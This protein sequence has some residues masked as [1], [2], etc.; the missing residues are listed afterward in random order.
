[1]GVGPASD[2]NCLHQPRGK[3][4]YQVVGYTPCISTLAVN[5]SSGS[6]VW[7]PEPPMGYWSQKNES[8]CEWNGQ[9][10]L[11]WVKSSRADPY[12]SLGELREY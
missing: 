4:M 11:C 7:Q 5:S 2:W 8:N 10:E 12:Q 1:M 6:K 9:T 3:G